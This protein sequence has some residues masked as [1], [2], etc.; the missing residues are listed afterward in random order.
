M[1]LARTEGDVAMKAWQ[2]SVIGILALLALMNGLGL[3]DSLNRWLTDAHW[4]F[5]AYFKPTPF[6]DDILIVAI[7]DKSLRKLGRL[8]YWS[9]KRYAQLLERLRLAKAVGI[10]ILFAEPDEK[11]PQGD[12]AFAAAVRRHGRVVLPFHQ[13]QG[14][15]L[16]ESE[17]EATKRLKLKLPTVAKGKTLHVPFAFV[18]TFQPPLPSLLD[19]A[20]AVGYADVNADP[21]GVYRKPIIL[22]QTSEGKLM[23]HFALAVACVAKGKRLTEVIQPV[24]LSLRFGER[25]VP[26]EGGALWLHHIARRSDLIVGLGS[27]VPTVS[28]VDALTMPPEKFAGKIVLVGETATGTT[29]IRPT[30]LDNGLRGVELN[31]EIIANLLYLPPVRPM[32]LALQLLLISLAAVVPLWLYSTTNVR[33][34][35]MGAFVTVFALAV[36]MEAAFWLGRWLPNFGVPL[37]AWL[38]STLLMGLQRLAQEEAQKRQIRQTFS[39]YVAPEVVEEI[40]RNPEI[41]HQE[42]VRQ[43]VAVLFSDIRGFTSYS[44]QNPPELVVRQMREYLTEMTAAVQNHRGVLDKFIGDAVMALYGPFLPDGTNISALAVASALEMLERLEKLNER[45]LQQGMPTF[46]IGIGIHVGEAMV[47]NIGSIQRVQ[48]TALGDTVNLASR[49]QSLTKDFKV[50][51]LVSEEVKEEAEKVL[52]DTVAFVDLGTVSVRGREK[53]VRVYAVKKREEANQ[54][55]KV[56]LHSTSAGGD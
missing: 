48:Y 42:G 28:F 37:L 26:L 15:I 33:M 52:G 43:R 32:P 45:W 23:P 12:A 5:R 53:P 16:S 51:L 56:T 35:T 22:R 46:R 40:V 34:A 44:E 11:D 49:L 21:D 13:W 19:A 9:R 47:G 20:S 38:S 41:A 7:D 25:V 6:P 8:R 14:R 50:P 18:E 39:L 2:K 55:L 31:A 1:R 3:T 29:D 30:P 17:R 10:D 4:R 24:P 27:P 36:L 54:A